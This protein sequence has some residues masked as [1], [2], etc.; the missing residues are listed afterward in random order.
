M[1]YVESAI[2]AAVTVRSRKHSGISHRRMG[3]LSMFVDIKV[4]HE[5][6]LGWLTDEAMFSKTLHP[7]AIFNPRY[8]LLIR[9]SKVPHYSHSTTYLSQPPG[10]CPNRLQWKSFSSS[11]QRNLSAACLTTSWQKFLLALATPSV[12]FRQ[13]LVDRPHQA[14][15]NFV[16]VSFKGQRQ[17]MNVV[18][19]RSLHHTTHSHLTSTAGND[20]VD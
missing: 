1:K 16:L 10:G 17:R 4:A 5:A 18:S 9:R 13:C 15:G 6:A 3:F 20:A 8:P 19:P 14:Y 12:P 2:R 7:D 11:M